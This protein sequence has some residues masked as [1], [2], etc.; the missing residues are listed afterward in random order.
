MRNYRALWAAGILLSFGT[1]LPAHD[2]LFKLQRRLDYPGVDTVIGKAWLQVERI[3]NDHIYFKA[4][5]QPT[6]GAGRV[7]GSD[8]VPLGL[9]QCTIIKRLAQISPDVNLEITKV[10]CPGPNGGR[11]YVVDE[12]LFNLAQGENK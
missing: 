7:S 10:H 1:W 6:L 12:V 5:I 3:D 8:N 4:L 11:E 9:A 2:G